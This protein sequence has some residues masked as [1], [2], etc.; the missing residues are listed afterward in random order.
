MDE[1][2][3]MVDWSSGAVELLTE[4]R[5]WPVTGRPRRAGVSSFGFGGTNAHVI[6][7]EAPAPDPAEPE[8]GT[9]HVPVP[10]L[11]WLLSGSTPRAVAAQAERLLAHVGQEPGPDALDVAYTLATGRAALGHRAVAVGTDRETLLE[12]LRD[13]GLV[14]SSVVAG[15]GVGLVFSGQGAQRAGMGRELAAVFPVFGRALD[16]VCGVLDPLLGGSLREVMFAADGGG[17]LDRTGWT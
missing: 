17:R 12:A 9:P 15:G 8:P 2:S 16:E 6:I 13:P 5:Q 3:P 7:E 11:P 10:A 4:A 14:V 1:P